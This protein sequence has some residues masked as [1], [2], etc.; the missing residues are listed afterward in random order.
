MDET[1]TIEWAR[2]RAAWEIQE[3][4]IPTD[5]TELL[6]LFHRTVVERHEVTVKADGLAAESSQ[7]QYL[8]VRKQTKLEGHLLIV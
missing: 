3:A 4:T 6:H 7:R 1:F 5:K 2:D 8:L